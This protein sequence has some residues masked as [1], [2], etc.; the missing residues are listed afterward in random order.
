MPACPGH[1]PELVAQPRQRSPSSLIRVQ[2]RASSGVTPASSGARVRGS[3]RRATR[4]R[5]A[6]SSRRDGRAASDSPAS[7]RTP[8]TLRGARSRRPRVLGL[9]RGGR[10]AEARSS[11][12]ASALPAPADSWRAGRRKCSEPA[13]L[14]HYRR[15]G[16]RGRHPSIEGTLPT[17]R[18]FLL[19]AL[20]NPPQRQLGFSP[21]PSPPRASESTRRT[22]EGDWPSRSAIERPPWEAC[23]GASASALCL[24]TGRSGRSGLGSV[25]V[26]FAGQVSPSH[27]QVMPPTTSHRRLQAPAG[28]QPFLSSS[29]VHP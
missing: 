23:P 8:R 13:P 4:P 22:P 1:R 10:R 15:F 5:A 21:S 19:D 20:A 29:R 3:E 26:S 16:G 18:D 25:P 24:G 11:P 27:S 17:L 12:R 14:S 28:Q 7:P 9:A 2:R 6:A